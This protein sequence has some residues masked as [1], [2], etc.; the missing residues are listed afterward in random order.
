MMNILC[1]FLSAFGHPALSGDVRLLSTS[2]AG[3]LN[4]NLQIFPWQ[5]KG[6]ALALKGLNGV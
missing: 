5:N 1:L 6:I 2:Y 4:L 3:L